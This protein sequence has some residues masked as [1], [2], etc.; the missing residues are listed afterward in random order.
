MFT[1]SLRQRFHNTV[2]PRIEASLT[3]RPGSRHDYQ[4]LA[5]HHYRAAAPAT[6]MRVLALEHDQPTVVGRYLHRASERRIAGVLVESLPSLSCRLREEATGDR[7]RSIADLRMR[8]KALNRELRCISRVVIH[9][10]WRGL[11][12][13]VRLVRAALAD[14]TTPMTEAIAAMGKVNPFFEHAGMTAYRAAPNETDGRLI[15]AME[16][17]GFR[18]T[19]TAMTDAMMLRIAALPEHQR[20]FITRELQR[21]HRRTM[22]RRENDLRQQIIDARQWLLCDAVYY[23]AVG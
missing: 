12:L 13:A 17:T 2:A 3:L 11:G 14:A 8:A 7:F 1:P 23:L 19:D 15:A 16:A 6:F 9:P 10:Q 21:W 20:A 18:P 5:E 22:H 4:R